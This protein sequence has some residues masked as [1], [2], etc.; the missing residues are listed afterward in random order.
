MRHHAY[1]VFAH[2]AQARNGLAQVL[3]LGLPRDACTLL[4][5]GDR[6]DGEQLAEMQSGARKIALLGVLVGAILGATVGAIFRDP[7]NSVAFGLVVG[8][9]MGA[10]L[11]GLFGGLAGASVADPALETLVTH[12][13]GESIL[14][15]VE[16]P[17]LTTGE[18]VEQ[19]L[20]ACG[21]ASVRWPWF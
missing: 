11:C 7:H 13:E 2:G 9:A 12:L 20:Y 4:A 21:G 18:A 8:G 10:I 1:A 6:L 16:S 15:V 3:A 19:A 17:D 14:L 5:R